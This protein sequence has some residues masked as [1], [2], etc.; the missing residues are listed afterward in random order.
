MEEAAD[1]SLGI[2]AR[3]SLKSYSALGD[4]NAEAETRGA[5][6]SGGTGLPGVCLCILIVE[7][8]ERLAFYTFTGTQEPFLENGGYTLSQSAGINAA[9]STLCM[10]WSLVACWSADVALGRYTTILSFG[11]LY[12]LGAGVAAGAAWPGIRNIG[13]YLFAVMVLVPFGTAGIKANISNFGADQYDTTVATGRQAQEKFFSWFYLSINLGSA[14]AYG[15]LTTLGSNGGLGIPKS[16]GYF[17]AYAIAA[18]CMFLAVCLFRSGRSR[19]Q[20]RPLQ[21]RWALFSVARYVIQSARKGSSQAII[22]CVG[23]LDL[24]AAIL[25]SVLQAMWPQAP[26]ATTLMGAAFTCAVVGVMATV[27]PCLN[28]SWVENSRLEGENFST[29]EVRTFLS[30]IPILITANLAF[31]ALY[32]SM[33]YWY[34]QQACQMDLRLNGGQLAG[35]F[36]MIADC[37]A[38]VLATP[39]AVGWLNPLLERKLA[40]RFSHTAKYGLGMFFGIVSVVLAARFELLRR[41]AQILPIGSNCAPSGIQMSAMSAAWMILPFFF[42]GVG[43][44]YTQPVLMHF[45]YTRSPPSMQTLVVAVNFLIGAVS[46]SIFTVQIAALSGFVPNDL[47]QGRLEIGYVSN[48]LIG[49]FFYAAYVYCAGRFPEK[50]PADG[51]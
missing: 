41:V 23:C 46:N 32:N 42:M 20:V 8:C 37:L 19:Y 47:N 15:Y 21:E 16:H 45:A 9:M 43:E 22:L 39:V 11:L 1:S 49:L 31:G 10:T 25:L 29:S 3:K 28:P 40:G 48:I 35:S 34:Q 26:C 36:F 33:Q 38:I 51:P 7:L 6:S 18:G 14:V 17:A 4:N 24:S 30:L 50:N 27:I 2:A 5:A 13:C 44:I 12:A